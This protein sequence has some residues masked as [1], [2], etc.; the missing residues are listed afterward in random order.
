[1]R[2]ALQQIDHPLSDHGHTYEA[3][4]AAIALASFD[5]DTVEGSTGVRWTGSGGKVTTRAAA[6]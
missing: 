5:D 1:M 2:Q 3:N 4:P 6:N